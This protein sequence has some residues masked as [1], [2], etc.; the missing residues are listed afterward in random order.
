M[1]HVYKS[2]ATWFDGA[3]CNVCSAEW[4]WTCYMIGK[5]YE[6][7]LQGKMAV[8]IFYLEK[9]RDMRLPILCVFRSCWWKSTEK[10]G[11]IIKVLV[12]WLIMVTLLS[13]RADILGSY[14]FKCK[15][16]IAITTI[17]A[18]KEVMYWNKV[19][20]LR[21]VVIIDFV[22]SSRL[23]KTWFPPWYI[24]AGPNYCSRVTLQLLSACC[25]HFRPCISSKDWQ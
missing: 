24:F 5:L 16:E 8:N 22:H 10:D 25:T 23:C 2:V 20:L 21:T 9:Q 19:R 13:W 18:N 14:E 3:F 12:C 6:K 11:E 15:A 4:Q 17:N 1:L 7:A